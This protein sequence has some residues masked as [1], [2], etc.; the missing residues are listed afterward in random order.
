MENE[1]FDQDITTE[2]FTISEQSEPPAEPFTI[3]S[4]EA[5]TE[6][7]DYAEYFDYNTFAP[8]ST[9]SAVTN[10]LFLGNNRVNKFTTTSS[11]DKPV[12]K[13][14]REKFRETILQMLGRQNKEAMKPSKRSQDNNK[15]EEKNKKKPN[16]KTST[17]DKKKPN[18]K[19][20]PEEFT[21]VDSKIDR[22]DK[23]ESK[24][25][26]STLSTFSTGKKVMSILILHFYP[27]KYVKKLMQVKN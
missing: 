14:G 3:S 11:P 21:T 5:V 6:A 12:E 4:L 19:N 13:T 26:T 23:S 20:I 8:D 9:E 16:K 27:S 24:Q 22:D 1:E 25:E 15:S 10:E 7:V 18:E 2:Q 17:S